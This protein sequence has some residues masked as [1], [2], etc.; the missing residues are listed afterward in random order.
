MQ[1][2]FDNFLPCTAL[3]LHCSVHGAHI[4]EMPGA[5]YLLQLLTCLSICSNAFIIA[6]L[7]RSIHPVPDN[8]E[9]DFLR[10]SS[11]VGTQSSGNGTMSMQSRLS[12][13]GRHVLVVSNT[14]CMPVYRHVITAFAAAASACVLISGCAAYSGDT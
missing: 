11:Y 12:V 13:K 1:L 4:A 6:D 14:H 8:L 5:V 7:V 3:A 10:I 2:R 9:M